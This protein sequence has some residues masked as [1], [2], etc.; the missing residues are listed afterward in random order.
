MDNLGTIKAIES[1]ELRVTSGKGGFDA[2]WGIY[3]ILRRSINAFLDFQKCVLHIAIIEIL[4]TNCGKVC[5]SSRL[6]VS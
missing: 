6:T 5:F 2:V 1:E 3:L 4:T